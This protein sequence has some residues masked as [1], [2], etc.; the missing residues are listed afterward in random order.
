[1]KSLFRVLLVVAFIY[2][3]IMSMKF[4]QNAFDQGDL[5]RAKEAFNRVQ[6]EDKTLWQL[7]AADLGVSSE[8]V[9]CEQY[10]VSRYSGPVVFECFAK[11]R[12]EV[13]YRFEAD[14]VQFRVSPQNDLAKN[15]LKDKS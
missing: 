4:L 12:V 15:L 6:V 14:V 11:E 1:M 13:Q 3:G 9:H 10:L 2:V 5:R 7:M 8:Q